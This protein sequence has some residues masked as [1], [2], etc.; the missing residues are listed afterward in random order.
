MRSS[1]HSQ[2]VHVPIIENRRSAASFCSEQISTGWNHERYRRHYFTSFLKE[3]IVAHSKHEL[4][5]ACSFRHVAGWRIMS[6]AVF[7]TCHE[8]E[9]R[10]FNVPSV[11]RIVAASV[12]RYLLLQQLLC[13]LLFRIRLFDPKLF[14]AMLFRALKWSR[15]LVDCTLEPLNEVRF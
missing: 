6:S 11:S 9:V 10:N 7:R 8:L 1:Q 5:E 4:H 2:K 14:G 12:L 3:E 15:N 13:L